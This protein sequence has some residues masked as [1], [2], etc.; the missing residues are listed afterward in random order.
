MCASP[1][2]REETETFDA[3]FADALA[4]APDRADA[5]RA[6]ERNWRDE[7]DKGCI[8]PNAEAYDRC[9]I[10]QYKIRVQELALLV[11][12]AQPPQAGAAI[13]P[14]TYVS[15]AVIF[16]LDPNGEFDMR[17]LAG[18]RQ[19]SG[20]YETG[21]GVLTLLDGA[22]DV[23]TTTFPLRCRVVRTPDGFAVRLGQA[24]CRQLDGLSFHQTT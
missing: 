21:G 7:R 14:G 18:G 17:D 9:I 23:G 12:K 8:M 19:A 10:A 15:D 16:R 2:L 13:D 24:S 20:H 22:G 5:L 4:R 11:P 3:A 6:T 1:A